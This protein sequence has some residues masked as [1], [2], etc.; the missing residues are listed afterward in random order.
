LGYFWRGAL[1]ADNKNPALAG[2]LA[3]V[4]IQDFLSCHNASLIASA[5]V[6]SGGCGYPARMVL[7]CDM[8]LF[9][10]LHG[11]RFSASSKVWSQDTSFFQVGRII[12]RLTPAQA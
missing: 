2:S 8:G 3:F 11:V 9:A 12:L 10:D 1:S 6:V 7:S 5:G 4:Q